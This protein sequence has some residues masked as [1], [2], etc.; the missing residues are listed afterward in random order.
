MQKCDAKRPCARCI[1]AGSTS[2]CA[3]E[4]KRPRP[5][6]KYS[7][8]STDGHLPGQPPGGA[9]PVSEIPAVPP[10]Y[11]PID[12]VVISPT[13]LNPVPSYPDTMEVVTNNSATLQILDADQVP[14]ERSSGLVLVRRNSFEQHVPLDVNPSISIASF[15]LPQSTTPELRIPLSFLGD[16]RLQVQLSDTEAT[17]LDMR[18]Y[19]LE[20]EFVGQ[21]L[22]PRY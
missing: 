8:Y 2:E 16:E 7:L 18:S 21:L 6:F 14:H 20:Q 22:T 13:K 19:V 15:F 11:S 10:T 1:L 9:D 17:D 5:A 12:D 4:E 3:Y